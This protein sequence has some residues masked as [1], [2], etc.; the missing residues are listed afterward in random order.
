LTL[1]AE[2][3][4]TGLSRFNQDRR[5]RC[6]A[7]I[8]EFNIAS[9]LSLYMKKGETNIGDISTVGC[10]ECQE[11]FSISFDHDVIN[12]PRC[13]RCG[14]V[15]EGF[16]KN[17]DRKRHNTQA[18]E[19]LD[20]LECR[21]EDILATIE[22]RNEV[23]EGNSLSVLREITPALQEASQFAAETNRKLNKSDD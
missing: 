9:E 23:P 2:D 11:V 4:E 5:A 8:H 14:T 16:E 12:V 1:L 10:V 22:Q 20:H 18:C 21:L 17:K 19:A 15:V 7:L 13:P 6:T 3:S